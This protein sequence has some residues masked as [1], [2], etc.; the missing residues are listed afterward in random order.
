MKNVNSIF[1]TLKEILR[2]IRE[3]EVL[4]D[5]LWGQSLFVREALGNNPKL[6]QLNP[7]QRML[8]AISDLFWEMQPANPP[9]K[10]KRLDSRW[11]EFGLLGAL[12]F[13]PIERGL[14]F[15]TSLLDAW[16]RIDT[17]ILYCV[18]GK[19]LENPTEEQVNTYR[20]VGA[21]A[22][23]ASTSTLS[24]WHN[25]SLKKLA[26]LIINREYRL[27]SSLG[28]LSPILNSVQSVSQST[29]HKME[30]PVKNTSPRIKKNPRY[31]KVAVFLLL[32]AT[33]LLVGAKVW[34]VYQ[35]GMAV[36]DD[37]VEL[38][39]TAQGSVDAMDLSSVNDQLG[40]LNTDLDM[41]TEEARPFIWLSSRL[42][43]I[44]KYGGDLAQVPALIELANR[45]VN[46]SVTSF[47][48]G[49]P[50]L[51]QIQ[52][53]QGSSLGP[54]DITAFLVDIQPQLSNIR[55]DLDKALLARSDIKTE[56]LSPR[57]HELVVN[58]VDPLL[59][60]M[61][62]GLLL[63][64]VLPSVLGATK[65]GPKTYL[66]LV[67]NEDELRPTGGFITT[68]GN[69]VIRNGQVLS[70]EFERVDDTNDWSKPY[71]PAP[72]QL[73]EY[74][75]AGVLIL[76]DSNWFTDF[77]TSAIWAEY[78]YAYDHSHSVDG[79]IAFDQQFLI[80]LLGV[81]GP[82]EVDGAPYPITSQNVVEYM[83]SA[84]APPQNEPLPDGWYRKEF[85]NNI[86]SAVL[87]Q[88]VNGQKND[89]RGLA[90]TLF[91]ALQERH[92]LLQF[93]DP[94]VSALL[95]KYDWDNAVR[96][97]SGDYLMVTDTNIGFNKT[98]AVVE[99]SLS[100]DVDLSNVMSPVGLLTVTHKN[101]AR[102]NIPCVQ[103]DTG[104]IPG[105]EWYPINRCYWSYLRVYKQ[106]GAELLGASPHAIPG[107][108]M[109][110]GKDVPARVD[111]LEEDGLDNAEGFG[112]LIVVPGG[113]S[114]STG[115]KFSLPGTVLSQSDSSAQYIYRLKVQKQ[116]GTR[117]NQLILRI[118]LP[119]HSRVDALNMDATTQENN[120]LIRTDLRTDVHLEVVFDIQ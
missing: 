41:F 91:Q 113:K 62:D 65:T 92:L 59:K 10:G 75:N 37:V 46:V 99:A 19:S 83:R 104:Q 97:A 98:N 40:N 102:D 23:F 49:Q 34:T 73:Q 47:E 95:T 31:I 90:A 15:P 116:P 76:R 105:E 114:L 117:A 27:S 80:M 5:H 67:Q 22:E 101:N 110:L 24:D 64:A 58:E 45:M 78:L 30:M 100:Y 3:P 50:L 70:L 7:G 21:E 61:D 96:P 87:G 43:W 25:K 68:V 60:M 26:E 103:W 29:S 120:L 1:E 2:H 72:W 48:A 112:T 56:K 51:S 94:V 12:Y 71:P 13:M 52:S 8:V 86:A 81:M 17:T 88:L 16:G 42:G 35:K 106:Q 11:G 18:F 108:W 119:N 74:M 53:S 44:P 107:E 9:R 66:V 20:L 109:L 111:I 85:I 14:P 33:L 28:M 69:M 84:K 39:E 4:D 93:D 79:V 89:W 54:S 77:P 82:L 36:Y 57:L 63:T 118:H 32:I 6:A 38:R 55:A 115:F